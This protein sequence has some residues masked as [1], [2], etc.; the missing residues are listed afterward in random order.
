MLN[1][2]WL[3]IYVSLPNTQGYLKNNCPQNRNW[4]VNVK[5]FENRHQLTYEGDPIFH[6]PPSYVHKYCVLR[7]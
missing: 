7:D 6:S 2:R 1:E 3:Y 5:E 4:V